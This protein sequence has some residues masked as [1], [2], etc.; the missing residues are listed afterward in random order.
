MVPLSF[1]D[2]PIEDVVDLFPDER[3]KAQKLDIN[4]VQSCLQQIPFPRVF[5]IEKIQQP[6]DEFLV[7]VL[8]DE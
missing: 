6:Q 2:E 5:R 3:T 7:N 1:V 8:F 4:S